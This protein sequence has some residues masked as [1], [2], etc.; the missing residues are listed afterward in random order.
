MGGGGQWECWAEWSSVC[1]FGKLVVFSFFPPPPPFF[2][3]L[4]FGGGG[5][6]GAG[7]GRGGGASREEWVEWS[8]LNGGGFV[9]MCM[10][11]CV[12]D[13]CLVT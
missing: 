11:V 8:C 12:F 7:A 4:F 13:M 6:V 5:G 2:P 10:C 3:S 9:C 1:L